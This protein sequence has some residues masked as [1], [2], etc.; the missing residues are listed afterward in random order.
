MAINFISSKD[1]DEECAMHS[2]SNNIEIMIYDKAHEVIQE[3]FESLLSRY[4]RGLEESIKG[5]DFFL[6]C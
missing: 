2:K 3:H 1:T 6:L 4:Q 5:Y